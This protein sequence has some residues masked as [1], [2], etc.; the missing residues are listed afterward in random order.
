M[1]DE[2]QN[3]KKKTIGLTCFQW[4]IPWHI[5]IQHNLIVAPGS[6]CYLFID[7][8]HFVEYFSSCANNWE[9]RIILTHLM[10]DMVELTIFLKQHVSREVVLF[11][12]HNYWYFITCNCVVYWFLH[13]VFF[14]LL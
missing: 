11:A 4:E 6:C 1:T 7:R 13:C 8:C 2:V 9:A 12:C 3:S 14:H 5:G 10:V